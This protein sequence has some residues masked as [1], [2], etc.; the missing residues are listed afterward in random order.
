[1][2][3]FIFLCPFPPSSLSSPLPSSLCLIVDQHERGKKP[4]I[5]V[6]NPRVNVRSSI[7]AKIVPL[8][9]K[10]H[11]GTVLRASASTRWKDWLTD[12]LEYRPARVRYN[13]SRCTRLM[14]ARETCF[15]CP[16]CMR[17]TR[18]PQICFCGTF[19]S[20]MSEEC[21]FSYRDRAFADLFR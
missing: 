14:H 9:S 10:K 18:P 20:S 4:E 21:L 16:N 6:E 8:T 7:L 11:E 1:M 2:S 5:Y 15:S 17:W 3:L 12:R 19:P 13:T